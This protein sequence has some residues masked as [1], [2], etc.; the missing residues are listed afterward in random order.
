MRCRLEDGF[1]LVVVERGYDRSHQDPGRHLGSAQGRK[2]PQARLRR[3]G[4]RLE[5]AFELVV[6]AR[7]TDPDARQTLARHFGEQVEVAQDHC[8]LGDD[9]DWMP[10]AGQHLENRA[11]H[12]HLALHRLVRVG[13]RPHG[14]GLA[15]I[16]WP[17]QLGLE[18]FR[19]VGLV[20][21]PRLKV[22]PGRQPE[23]RVART[24]KAVMGDDTVADVIPSFRRDVIQPNC[25]E[26]LNADDTQVRV[27]RCSLAGDIELARY[28]RADGMEETQMLP[29]TSSDRHKVDRLSPFTGVVLDS[30]GKPKE[31]Q[32]AADPTDDL[33]VSVG[34]AKKSV[35]ETPSA[36]NIP[37][38]KPA[39]QF[40]VAEVGHAT[41]S[42][43]ACTLQ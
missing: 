24:G 28:G 9:G 6:E 35:A 39:D 42:R 15:D 22:E 38:R 1:H 21:E 8:A 14:Y 2:R 7:D 31:P 11:R 36:S 32:A 41:S 43:M 19:G 10:R 3:G 25:L 29:E 20:E 17:R 23:V 5:R 27:A 13:V 33:R 34:N 18:H 40:A 12:L 30:E 4:A 26:A 37:A 16:I